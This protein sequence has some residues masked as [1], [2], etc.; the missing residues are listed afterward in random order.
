M[1]SPG[2]VMAP[3]TNSNT[4]EQ[5]SDVAQPA[6][7]A[8]PSPEIQQRTPRS[9]LPSQKTSSQRR[10]TKSPAPVG[11][12]AATAAAE[13]TPRSTV[14]HATDAAGVGPLDSSDGEEADV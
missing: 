9:W 11:H 5:T 7:A 10:S 8:Q 13:A 1:M 4:S 3:R 6:T 14:S 12:W 2:R